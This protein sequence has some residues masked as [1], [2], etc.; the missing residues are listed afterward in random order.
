L[1]QPPAALS[2]EDRLRAAEPA[3]KKKKKK[4][5]QPA[6]IGLVRGGI[7]ENVAQWL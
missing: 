2:L 3:P 4:K 5:K 1:P 7:G 6:E